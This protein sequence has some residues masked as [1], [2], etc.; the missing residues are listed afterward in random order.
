MIT[1]FSSWAKG[2]VVAVVISKI[3]EL[4]LPSG[5]QKKYIK[6]VLGVF[7]LFTI[8][9]P[10]ID[11]VSNNKLDVNQIFNTKADEDKI[12]KVEETIAKKLESSN[13]RSIKDIYVSNLE[14]DIK[15]KLNEKGYEVNSIYIRVKDDEN[16]TIESVELSIKKNK[17]ENKNTNIEKIEINV[18]VGAKNN[19]QNQI[20]KLEKSEIE[21]IKEILSK[22]YEINEDKVEIN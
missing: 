9:S 20:S 19:V 13:S 14:N 18:Q 15:I 4:V 17:E 7:I 10:I 6:V 22:N 21:E 11:K 1:F 2:I 5:S 12:E 3:I 8:I 16:Y